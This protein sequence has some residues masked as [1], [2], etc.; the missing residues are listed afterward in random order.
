[1]RTVA[2]FLG[3]ALLSLS[4]AAPARATLYL[5]CGEDSCFAPTGTGAVTN[6]IASTFRSGWARE[7][8]DVHNNNSAADP[9]VDFWHSPTFSSVSSL[10]I[11]GVIFTT[12]T[13]TSVANVQGLRVYSPDGVARILLRQTA[14]FGQIKLSSRNA[15]GTI[16]DLATASANFSANALT[17]LDLFINYTCSGAGGV[18]LYENGTQVINFSGNP[19]TDAATSLNALDLVQLSGNAGLCTSNSTQ[20]GTC[21]S[22]L[23]VQS[24]S[25]LG[26]GLLSLTATGAGA[27][28]NWVPNTLANINKT[29]NND[30]TSIA[31][32]STG[33]LSEWTQGT[34]IPTGSFGVVA[35]TQDIR[36]E[37]GTSGPQTI[38]PAVHVGG[39][40]YTTL[41]SISPGTS[42]SNFNV[43][44]PT[45]PA[46]SSAWATTD[47]TAPL[48]WGIESNP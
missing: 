25:T 44:W 22:E 35:V 2:K 13:G 10:W 46:T 14:T 26:E 38:L 5:A 37:R 32:T 24:T 43:I 41:P 16:T 28:Q 40:D 29:A 4:L 1:M 23:I 20:S 30:A 17:Q 19:C 9:P 12:N 45:N 11:H 48:Q 33:V 39:T 7:A 31:A 36:A 18:Q 15:A 3:A 6:T 21:W 34:A 42:Y 27:T 8:L 47:I